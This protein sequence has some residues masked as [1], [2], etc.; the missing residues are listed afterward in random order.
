MRKTFLYLIGGHLATISIPALAQDVPATPVPPLPDNVGG[1]ELTPDQMAA[2][3]TWPDDKRAMYDAWPTDAQAYFWTLPE[4]RQSLFWRLGDND[5]LAIVAMSDPDRDAAWTMIEE[6]AAALGDRSGDAAET[7][8][9]P[10]TEPEA[11]P[12]PMR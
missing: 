6:R 7:P 2:Y 8:A 12:E 10:Y 5:K 1:G 9:E 11:E 4:A 3:E